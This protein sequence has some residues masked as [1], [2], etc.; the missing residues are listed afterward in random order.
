MYFPDNTCLEIRLVTRLDCQYEEMMDTRK[1]LAQTVLRHQVRV[2]AYPDMYEELLADAALQELREIPA[3]YIH[4]FRE[5]DKFDQRAVMNHLTT[6]WNLPNL[7]KDR[8]FDLE[9]I[10]AA[11]HQ[12]VDMRPGNSGPQILLRKIT[13]WWRKTQIKPVTIAVCGRDRDAVHEAL[14]A[15][16]QLLASEYRLSSRNMTLNFANKS[17][18]QAWGMLAATRLRI[19]LNRLMGSGIQAY[20]IEGWWYDTEALQDGFQPAIS[21]WACRGTWQPGDRYAHL[22]ERLATQRPT[23][24]YLVTDPDDPDHMQHLLAQAWMHSRAA[25]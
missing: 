3:R 10:Q 22:F 8:L 9:A 17:S 16:R 20:V 21:V 11:I 23:H 25:A 24:A 15:Y 1:V 19:G 14:D 13:N 18:L 5:M 2:A 12:A 6:V 4:H 7:R